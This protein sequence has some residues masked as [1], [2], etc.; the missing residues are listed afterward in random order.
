[1]WEQQTSAESPTRPAEITDYLEDSGKRPGVFCGEEGFAS[2]H[3]PLPL[4]T[5]PSEG[6][7]NIKTGGHQG[8]H[9]K[10]ADKRVSSQRRSHP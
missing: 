6:S 10:W 1:M 4:R 8:L 3:L 5:T 7:S 9:A 2:A